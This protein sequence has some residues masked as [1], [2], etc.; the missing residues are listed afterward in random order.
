MRPAIFTPVTN[1]VNVLLPNEEAVPATVVTLVTTPDPF[2]DAGPLYYLQVIRQNPSL[3]SGVVM[4][5]RCQA[6]LDNV[7]EIAMQLV[8]AAGADKCDAVVGV[9]TTHEDLL[10]PYI[11]AAQLKHEGITDLTKLVRRKPEA[12]SQSGLSFTERQAHHGLSGSMPKMNRLLV[13]DDFIATGE[14]A[15]HIIKLMRDQT[16]SMPDVVIAAPLWVS[17][18]QL[19]LS[20]LSKQEW[21]QQV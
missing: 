3:M 2:R 13:L 19:T 12:G 5:A 11:M 16:Q 17:P 8:T 15:A 21:G 18:G 6:Y 14:S 7:T 10:Q 20:F 1:K 9:P 4:A